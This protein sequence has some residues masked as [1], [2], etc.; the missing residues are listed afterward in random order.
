MAFI[1]STG[2]DTAFTAT[3]VKARSGSS[4]GSSSYQGVRT[5]NTPVY[6][7]SNTKSLYK[8]QY[9]DT[10][11]KYAAL[12]LTDFSNDILSAG[13]TYIDTVEQPD[14]TVLMVS[15]G[16][17]MCLSYDE[18]QGDGT[19]PLLGWYEYD[20]GGTIES[21]ASVPTLSDDRIWVIVNRDGGR[22]V[23]YLYIG[24]DDI[25]VD[26]AITYSGAATRTFTGLDHLEGETV[27][28]L[29]DG[30]YAG[31]Y[32]VVSGSITIPDSKSAVE[33]AYIGLPYNADFESMPVDPQTQTGMTQ[34]QMNRISEVQFI[35]YRTKGISVGESFSNLIVEPIRNL[36]SNMN[37]APA[38]IGADYPDVAQSD[39][40][41][42]WGRQN[43]I[44]LR[45][46]LPFPC[47][48]VAY[49]AKMEVEAN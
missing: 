24:D 10:T 5:N 38:F 13:S 39:F 2:I 46:S 20:I 15:G 37:K 23:E 35:L 36:I 40:N 6:S 42:T 21:V 7:H 9:D 22:Y 1:G 47:T 11:L 28:V 41:G 44:C 49:M 14:Q 27:S 19:I 48:L 34:T 18:S 33:L 8:V 12:D 4:F 25:Y 30:S 16:S 26:S 29:G 17:L 43:T 3:N 32:E 45:S 31:D